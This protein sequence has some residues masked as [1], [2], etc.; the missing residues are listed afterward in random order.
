M[1][2]TSSPHLDS[3]GKVWVLVSGLGGLDLGVWGVGV[4][5]YSFG[6]LGFAAY[7]ASST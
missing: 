4:V 1:F 3:K 5:V 2:W 6:F 7:N